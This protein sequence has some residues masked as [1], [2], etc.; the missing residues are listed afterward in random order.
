MET[1]IREGLKYYEEDLK[2]K[3]DKY[4]EKNGRKNYTFSIREELDKVGRMSEKEFY[5]FL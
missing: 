1:E 2:E 4:H 3:F 5:K